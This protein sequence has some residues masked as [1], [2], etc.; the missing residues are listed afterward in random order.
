MVFMFVTDMV[1]TKFFLYY[2]ISWFDMMMHFLGGLWVGLFFIWFFPPKDTSFVSIV[3]IFL[4]VLFVGILW[5]FFELYVNNFLARMSFNPRDTL[6]DIFFDL[7]GGLLAVLY[8]F[9]SGVMPKSS[10]KVQ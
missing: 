7:G 4:F 5:E 6:S 8:L 1:A 3:K 9:K 10:N 2:S